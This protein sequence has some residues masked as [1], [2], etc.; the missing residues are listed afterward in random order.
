MA[1]PDASPPP[2]PLA[3]LVQW[4]SGANEERDSAPLQFEREFMAATDPG[5]LAPRRSIIDRCQPPK[6][7]VPAGHSST[8]LPPGGK[9][10]H[11][12]GSKRSWVANIPPFA[13]H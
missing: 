4:H 10:S 13:T 6:A 5:R 12:I 9:H 7:A 11:Q 2:A 1:W 3:G 8:P